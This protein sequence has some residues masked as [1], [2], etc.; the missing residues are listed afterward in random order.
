MKFYRLLRGI[1]GYS[2]RCFVSGSIVYDLKVAQVLGPAVLPFHYERRR[3]TVT[4]LDNAALYWK[5]N[6]AA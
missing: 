3:A 1:H 4:N 2:L 5:K 6:Y